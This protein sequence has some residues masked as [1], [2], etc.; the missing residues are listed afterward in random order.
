M[1]KNIYF[2]ISALVLLTVS[3]K[4]DINIPDQMSPVNESI[5]KEYEIFSNM[6]S[7]YIQGA[8]MLE[9]KEPLFN[10]P[11]IVASVEAG[12][13]LSTRADIASINY[14]DLNKMVD[15]YENEVAIKLNGV[16]NYEQLIQKNKNEI[17]ISENAVIKMGEIYNF[18]TT[19]GISEKDSYNL[20]CEIKS[21]NLTTDEKDILTNFLLSVSTVEAIKPP[22]IFTPMMQVTVAS[23]MKAYRLKVAEVTVESELLLVLAGASLTPFAGA[24]IVAITVIRLEM[25]KNER[26][27]CLSNAKG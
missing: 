23:C 14:Q 22:T 4:E 3:C 16:T 6:K 17:R 5:E 24:L 10:N 9:G 18:A 25:A 15:A 13:T 1:K 7:S 20:F 19:V 11:L 8:K 27:D 21:S 26:D 12:Q 2:L